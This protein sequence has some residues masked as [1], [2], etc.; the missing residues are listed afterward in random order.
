VPPVPPTI[1]PAK[2]D[3]FKTFELKVANADADCRPQK[4]VNKMFELTQKYEK[5]FID[6]NK[7]LLEKLKASQG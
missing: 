4:D 6:E 1:A 5:A 2:I 7:A 3:E